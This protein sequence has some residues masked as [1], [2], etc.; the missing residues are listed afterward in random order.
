MNAKDAKDRKGT[1]RNAKEKRRK[2]NRADKVEDNVTPA[3]DGYQP[4]A[5]VSTKI[6]NYYT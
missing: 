6:V 2:L 3:Y 1:Q 4:G 5:K